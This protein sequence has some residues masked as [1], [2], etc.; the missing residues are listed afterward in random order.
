MIDGEEGNEGGG[1]GRD[2]VAECMR[3]FVGLEMVRCT[4]WKGETDFVEKHVTEVGCDFE[5]EER[6]L[7]PIFAVE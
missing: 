5:V 7:R 4:R 2:E 3:L 6:V 1:D